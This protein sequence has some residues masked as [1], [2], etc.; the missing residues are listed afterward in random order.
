M[1]R[2]QP[3]RE[4]LFDPEETPK[5]FDRYG[6][7]NSKIRAWPEQSVPE[8]TH[9]EYGDYNRR[10]KPWPEREPDPEPRRPV[11]YPDYNRKIKGWSED[12]PETS[13][14]QQPPPQQQQ[15][16][17][18]HHSANEVSSYHSNV[19]PGTGK[20]FQKSPLSVPQSYYS[21]PRGFGSSPQFRKKIPPHEL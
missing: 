10:I 20:S 17:H 11:E 3:A 15:Q 9:V 7:Y 16:H 8:E 21:L 4:D 6:N 14:Q 19:G 2:S 18:Q 13:Q 12:V 1:D 5:Q